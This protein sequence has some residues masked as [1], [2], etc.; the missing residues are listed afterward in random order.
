MLGFWDSTGWFF[1]LKLS[2]PGPAIFISIPVLENRTPG[3][4]ELRTPRMVYTSIAGECRS[5]DVAGP[6]FG[7]SRCSFFDGRG[8][9]VTA[10]ANHEQGTAADAAGRR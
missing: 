4:G 9:P 5:V 1:A 2:P 7:S 6:W 8:F 3:V 10:L